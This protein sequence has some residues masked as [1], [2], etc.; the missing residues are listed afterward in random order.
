MGNKSS[1]QNKINISLYSHP[2]RYPLQFIDHTYF[3]GESFLYF[4]PN[5]KVK[6][7][8][9][10]VEIIIKQEGVLDNMELHKIKLLVG[11][12]EE[13]SK[14]QENYFEYCKE[15]ENAT[16]IIRYDK[17]LYLKEFVY[18]TDTDELSL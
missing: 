3:N 4:K 1:I 2:N 15:I 7:F 18:K 8:E 12:M 14:G 13:Y 16:L 10:L 9:Y 17:H 5:K 6:L 11:D